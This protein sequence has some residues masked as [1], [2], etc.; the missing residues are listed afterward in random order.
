MDHVRST[1]VHTIFKVSV[2]PSQPQEESRS[3]ESRWQLKGADDQVE[4]FGAVRNMQDNAK[5]SGGESEKQKP[6]VK[7]KTVG[8][9]DLCPCGSGLKYKKCHG[10]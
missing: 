9:N 8:R 6:I 2:A 7:E 10:K 3:D 1:I 4:Q 5:S